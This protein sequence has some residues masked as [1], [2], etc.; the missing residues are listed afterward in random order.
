MVTT[1]AAIPFNTTT[2]NLSL[3][4]TNVQENSCLFANP[5]ASTDIQCQMGYSSV[6][7]MPMQ[8]N[9]RI[10]VEGM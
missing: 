1:A 4:T 6:G 9:L 5:K 2:A 7:A 3:N 10:V 8:Y